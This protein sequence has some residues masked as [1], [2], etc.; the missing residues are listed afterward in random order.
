[1]L[2]ARPGKCVAVQIRVFWHC[3]VVENECFEAGFFSDLYLKH[4]ETRDIAVFSSTFSTLN[5]LELCKANSSY[6]SDSYGDG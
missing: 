3:F 6:T 5:K 4:K 1:M 2:T